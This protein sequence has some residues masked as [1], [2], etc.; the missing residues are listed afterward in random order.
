MSNKQ[1]FITPDKCPKC[2]QYGEAVTS[3]FGDFQGSRT[4]RCADKECQCV[5][6]TLYTLQATA[7]TITNE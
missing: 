3:D 6:E 7:Q 5:W 2:G 4:F 1:S